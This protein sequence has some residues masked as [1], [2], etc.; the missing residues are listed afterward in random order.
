M[1]SYFLMQ[2]LGERAVAEKLDQTSPY[3]EQLELQ[4]LQFLA[5]AVV[6][7]HSA[8]IPVTAEEQQKRYEQ[9]KAEKYEKAKI[10]AIMIMYGDK[11]MQTQINMADP[12]IRR[13]RP[14][15]RSA[16]RTKRNA[17]LQIW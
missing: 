6:N 17:W 10:R 15:L 9:E 1:Q 11:M 8:S 16:K 12:T 3:K 4:R 7:R 5:T 13:V 14:K 2:S